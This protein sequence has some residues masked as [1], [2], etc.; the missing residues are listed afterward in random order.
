MTT[1]STAV[2]LE[3]I[4]RT[5]GYKINKGSFNKGTKNL[6][7]IIAVFAEANIANQD[8]LDTDK[9]EITTA[10]EAAEL[11]GYGSPMHQIYRILRPIGSDG[12]GG[13]P[14]IAFVQKSDKNAMPTSHT[15]TIT[16]SATSS[17]THTIVIGGRTS[18]DFESYS[19]SITK[20]DTPEVIVTK[21]KDAVNGVLGSPVSA[22]NNGVTLKLTTKWS[23][24]TSKTLVTNFNFG[25]KSGGISYSKT[26]VEEGVGEVELK[27]ALDQ[28][29]NIWYTTVINSYGESVFD[30]L[31][32]FNGNPVQATGRYEGQVF[33]PFLSFF[34]TT[35]D[36]KD[37]ILAIT[38]NS[39]RIEQVTH[40]H[41]PA[42]KSSGF[43]W[44]AAANVIRLFTRTMQDTPHLDINNMSYPDMPIPSNELI[45][46]MSSY[47]NRDVLVKKGSST[48]VLENGAY[49]I[50]DLVTTYHPKGE[51]PLQYA[52]SRNINL[53]WNVSDNY[54][55]LETL[56][57]KDHVLIQNNQATSVSKAIK[58]IEWKA[59]VQEMFVDLANTALIN[60]PDFSKESLLVEISKNNPNRFETFFRYKRTGIAR[61]ESTDVEAGF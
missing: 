23:G 10:K 36:D 2:G 21:I 37:S 13:I 42:P 46:D 47:N 5:S 1:I 34:G 19:Y 27:T 12:V 60:D 24:N 11:Y 39:S 31:E 55:T 3:R 57:I 58:P 17:V 41:C 4:S 33:K 14:T 35:L 20:G 59:I 18:L 51:S 9:K 16:G 43:P 40:V 48:V 22:S 25:T 38:D 28:F 45:G 52:Y 30:V 7:Q 50:Q 56:F 32:Q 26:E 8:G 6:P 54:R 53:D 15:W 49:K 44:E 29:D 61:I